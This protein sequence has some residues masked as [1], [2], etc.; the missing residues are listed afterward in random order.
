MRRADA[1]EAARVLMRHDPV[2]ARRAP[3]RQH[4]HEIRKTPR[5]EIMH[6]AEADAGA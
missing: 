2:G 3:L 4:A 5:D 6:D 1:A